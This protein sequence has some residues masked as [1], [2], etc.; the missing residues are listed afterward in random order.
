MKKLAAPETSVVIKENQEE[1][2]PKSSEMWWIE[3]S[4][5]PGSVCKR[6]RVLSLS[7][8]TMYDWGNSPHVGNW[9]I[10]HMWGIEAGKFK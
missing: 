5:A 1:S 7:T 8:V 3:Q 9:T 6:P 2:S 10:H 4:K